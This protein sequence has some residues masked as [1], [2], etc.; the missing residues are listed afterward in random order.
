MIWKSTSNKFKLGN[1]VKRIG[2]SWVDK[3]Y[4][5]EALG[6]VGVIQ[7]IQESSEWPPQSGRVLPKQYFIHFPDLYKGTKRDGVLLGV[8]EEDLELVV[9]SDK[10]KHGDRFYYNE[11]IN[12]I[13]KPTGTVSHRRTMY[14]DIGGGTYLVKYDNLLI[15]DHNAYENYMVKI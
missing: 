11:P 7:F 8:V 10:F 2:S 13:P 9:H 4:K 6:M 3:G 5:V 15:T 14:G 12:G 1:T